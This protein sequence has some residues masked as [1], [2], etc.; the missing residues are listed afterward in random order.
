MGTQRAGSA[1][2]VRRLRGGATLARPF[3]RHGGHA[4]VVGLSVAVQARLHVSGAERRR[5][6]A[7]SCC[8]KSPA[9]KG[10]LAEHRANA[11]ATDRRGHSALDGVVVTLDEAHVGH[12][13]D[14]GALGARRS[15]R[16]LA[17]VGPS[18]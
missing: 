18:S 14:L 1:A 8:A 3:Y 9:P 7:V 4:E 10:G 11:G 17:R 5:P 16:P 13:D 2:F 12:R 15:S 6:R